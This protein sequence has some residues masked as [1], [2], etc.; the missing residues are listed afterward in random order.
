VVSSFGG[1]SRLGGIRRNCR[2]APIVLRREGAAPCWNGHTTFRPRKRCG[3]E[4]A[5]HMTAL[6][7]NPGGRCAAVGDPVDHDVGQELVLRED[8]LQIA[9]VVAP[10]VPLFD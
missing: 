10:S 5:E 2:S 8:L 7:V 6:V 3:S 4:A 9:V 1:F